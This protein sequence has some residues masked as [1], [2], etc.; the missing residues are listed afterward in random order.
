MVRNRD[1]LDS[2][3]DGKNIIFFENELIYTVFIVF[4][5]NFYVVFYKFYLISVQIFLNFR[6][7]NGLEIFDQFLP[8]NVN[9]WLSKAYLFIFGDNEFAFLLKNLPQ[10][11]YNFFLHFSK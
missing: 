3:W 1:W 11:S 6:V 8:E 7:N 10:Q 5:T 2:P 4:F 9:F